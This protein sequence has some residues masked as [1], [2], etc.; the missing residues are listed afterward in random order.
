M[1]AREERLTFEKVKNVHFGWMI[2]TPSREFYLYAL[3][4]D[5][6]TEWMAAIKVVIENM[7]IVERVC[8]IYYYII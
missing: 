8:M 6:R 4:E 3:D 5:T 7:A 1:S 2:Y